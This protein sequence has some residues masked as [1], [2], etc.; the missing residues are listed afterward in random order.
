MSKR[1]IANT[2]SS[3][4]A[5]STAAN[6]SKARKVALGASDL[7]ALYSDVKFLLKSEPEEFS[8]DTLRA[9]PDETSIWDGIRNP[10]ARYIYINI[11]I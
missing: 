7:A 11:C 1:K 5:E 2:I 9:C 4:V 8:I 6:A 3:A 10:Q